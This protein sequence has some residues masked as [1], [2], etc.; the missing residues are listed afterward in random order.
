MS[1]CPIS[2]FIFSLTLDSSHCLYSKRCCKSQRALQQYPFFYTREL[3]WIFFL[4]LTEAVVIDWFH[5]SSVL[6][7]EVSRSF[8]LT[9]DHVNCMNNTYCPA[10]QWWFLDGFLE[11]PFLGCVVDLFYF[12]WLSIIVCVTTCC[13]KC[14]PCLGLVYFLI[15][16]YFCLLL[17]ESF[18][19][20]PLLFSRLMSNHLAWP[21]FLM[22]V[23]L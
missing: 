21:F 2:N 20:F 1:S 11:L 22:L 8:C 16:S 3:F 12:I 9:E 14:L 13:L 6:Y 15:H 23:Q 19:S 17:I 5:V 10:C 4:R 18:L 7:V